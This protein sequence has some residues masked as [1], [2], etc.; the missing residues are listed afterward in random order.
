MADATPPGLDALMEFPADFTFRVIAAHSETLIQDAEGHVQ[1]ALSRDVVAVSHAASRGGKW[2]SVRITAR[3]ESIEEVYAAY[4][5]LRA[6]P[7]I[8]LLL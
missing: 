5:A 1:R 4:E 6:L 8:K 3:V 2:T 7:R